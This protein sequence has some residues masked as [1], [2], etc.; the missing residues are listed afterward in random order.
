MIIKKLKVSLVKKMSIT[1]RS[2]SDQLKSKCKI[3]F[4]IY[5]YKWVDF[6]QFLRGQNK[7]VPK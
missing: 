7:K 1:F 5:S 4:N 2:K 6:A 3:T